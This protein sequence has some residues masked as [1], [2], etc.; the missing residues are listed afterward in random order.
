MGFARIFTKPLLLQDLSQRPG[1]GEGQGQKVGAS[2]ADG[3][4]GDMEKYFIQETRTGMGT[5]IG[6]GSSATIAPRFSPEQHVYI[7]L[8][9][10]RRSRCFVPAHLVSSFSYLATRLNEIS[11]GIYATTIPAPLDAQAAWGF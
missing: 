10:A 8:L 7:D 1:Q 2:A 5:G 9:V 6:G 4:G 11:K 3:A